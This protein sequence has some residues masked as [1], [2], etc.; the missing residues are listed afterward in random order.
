MK[1]ILAL[2]LSLLIAPVF[3][4][5][6]GNQSGLNS[7][8]D[9]LNFSL[10]LRPRYEHVDVDE[11]TKDSANALTL[12]TSLG[13]GLTNLFKV[14]GL[15]VYLEATDV[16]NFGLVDEYN[17]T[18]AIGGN[19]N[20]EYEAVVD[21]PITRMTQAYISYTRSGMT[22]GGGRRVLNLD[23]QRFIGA[24]NW[25]QMP[26]TFGVVD[27]TY[28]YDKKARIYTAYVYERKGIKD[29]FSEH[30]EG[31]NSFLANANYTF[32][33]LVKAAAY[34]YLINST[35]D[36]YG[37]RFTGKSN[38]N[39]TGVHYA[40][41]GALQN[42]SSI[43][44]RGDAVADSYY[45]N[46]EAGLDHKGIIL[47][48][49]YEVLGEADGDATKGFSTPWATLHKFNGWSDVLLGKAAGGDPDGIED[50]SGTVGYKHKSLGKLLLVYHQ[51]DSI[52]NSKDY[53]NEIDLVYVK[54]IKGI[55]VVAKAA[56]YD[57]GD[58]FGQDTKKFW[59]MAVYKFNKSIKALTD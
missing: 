27:F 31:I 52:E 39:A 2:T 51:F 34:A 37:L 53:G 54:K 22:L 41:E 44:D 58:D 1:K 9:E 29:E 11:S 23:N 26:Q 20:A 56:F 30:T 32:H 43:N 45:Y 8:A 50:L 5:F 25:R 18:S 17:S 12:R 47:K 57:G 3:T 24:V 14:K 10:L 35:H 33:P 36:T 59:L 21:P 55:E 28:D 49:N 6:A 16:S 40:L 4:A 48:G 15:K 46:I 7:L 42:D 38:V 13:V 19:D